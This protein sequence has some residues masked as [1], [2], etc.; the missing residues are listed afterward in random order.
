MPGYAGRKRPPP[1]KKQTTFVGTRPHTPLSLKH[2][3]EPVMPH[4]GAN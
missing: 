4:K 3:L 1:D 2:Q